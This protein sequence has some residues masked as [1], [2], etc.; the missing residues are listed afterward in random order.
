MLAV[1][2]IS[3]C[4]LIDACKYSV[5]PSPAS[6]H[7]S[8]GVHMSRRMRILLVDEPGGVHCGCTYRMC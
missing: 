4:I 5:P 6:L 2:V 1:S 3:I 8:R 7:A